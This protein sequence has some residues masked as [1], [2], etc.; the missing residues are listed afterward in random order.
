MSGESESD[1]SYASAEESELSDGAEEHCGLTS[2][3]SDASSV[4]SLGVGCSAPSTISSRRLGRG[5]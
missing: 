1:E 3:S 5:K 4:S 2:S